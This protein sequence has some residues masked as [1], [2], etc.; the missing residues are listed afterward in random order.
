MSL[1]RVYNVSITADGQ[2]VIVWTEYSEKW[3][4]W[5][6]MANRMGPHNKMC[7]YETIFP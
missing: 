4:K 2:P 5:N 7:N 3:T 6:E 1:L